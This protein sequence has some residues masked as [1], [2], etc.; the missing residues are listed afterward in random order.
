MLLP[1]NEVASIL[2]TNPL[3]SEASCIVTCKFSTPTYDNTP[4]ITCA[5]V[6]PAGKEVEM[7]RLTSGGDKFVKLIEGYAD[8]LKL[9]E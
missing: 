3:A 7:C 2:L 9:S 4:Q 6:V 8:C 5:K 1:G